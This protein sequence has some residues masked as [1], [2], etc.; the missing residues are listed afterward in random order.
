MEKPLFS[1]RC[2]VCL[3]KEDPMIIIMPNGYWRKDLIWVSYP[4][5]SVK[6]YKN[7]MVLSYLFNEIV[8]KYEEIEY[9]NFVKILFG[10]SS[11]IVVKHINKKIPKNIWFSGIFNSKLYAKIRLIFAKN[12]IKLKF[13]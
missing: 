11:L 4:L 13:I 1:R 7:K 5:G 6:F 10:L 8:L 12:N 3:Q 2:A 9:F